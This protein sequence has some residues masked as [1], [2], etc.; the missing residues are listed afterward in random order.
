[1]LAVNGGFDGFELVLLEDVDEFG[2]IDGGHS[3]FLLGSNFNASC[4]C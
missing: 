4:C 3:Y 1:M 2:L